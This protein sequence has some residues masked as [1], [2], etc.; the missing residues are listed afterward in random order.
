M[1]S[2]ALVEEARRVIAGQALFSPLVPVAGRQTP[3]SNP[4]LLK[5]ESLQ[6]GGSFKLRGALNRLSRLSA[7][8]RAAGVIAYSTGNHAQAVALAARQLGIPATIVMSPDAPSFKVA[9]TQSYGA[10]VVMAEPTSEARRLLAEAIARAE[11][12][13]LVPPYDHPDVIAGQGT[14]GLEILEQTSPAAVFVPVGGGGLLAGIALAIK[15]RAPQV[16]VI[17][18]EPE[19]ED[20]ASR[21]LQSGERVRLPG[22]SQ[23]I[24]DAIRVQMLGDLTW[25]IIR[26]N[27]DQILTVSE[28]AIASATLIAFHEAHLVLEPA[29]ALGLAAA[30]AYAESLP[31]GGAVVAVASGG[32]TRLEALSNLACQIG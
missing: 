32:N 30:L 12:L 4:I 11:G 1:S 26:R 24:A 8:E 7:A 15:A 6:P 13:A 25:P 19:W 22:P 10:R 23:S 18:V 28:A 2:L 27:V 14:I 3:G 20:D 31:A 16:R 17:G 21:S 9:A 29:G 5:A